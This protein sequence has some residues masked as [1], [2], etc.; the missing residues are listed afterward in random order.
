[1]DPGTVGWRA[2]NTTWSQM[3][4]KALRPVPSTLKGDDDDGGGGD[5][6]DDDDDADVG[7]SPQ[8]CFLGS[9][10]SALGGLCR[11]GRVFS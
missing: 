9:L 7:Q 1:M 2:V 3:S 5:G 11:L 10:R 6:D 4:A 8:G